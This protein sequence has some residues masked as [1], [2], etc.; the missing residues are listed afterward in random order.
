[1]AS[2]LRIGTALLGATAALAF[3]ALPAHA[4]VIITPDRGGQEKGHNVWLKPV[5]T[6]T[7]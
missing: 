6:S 3:S 1:M 4:D 2:R 7:S 5:G